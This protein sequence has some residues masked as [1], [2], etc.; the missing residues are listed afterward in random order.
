MA[1]RQTSLSTIHWNK[2]P[3]SKGGL[4]FHST[5]LF[6]AT[7]AGSTTTI[8]SSSLSASADSDFVGYIVECVK[9]TNSQNVGLLRRIKACDFASDTLTI[10]P[11][12]AATADEDQFHLYI[13]DHVLV[14]AQSA[15]S[16]TNGYVAARDRDEADDYWNG[17]TEEGGSYL[18]VVNADNASA[19]NHILIDDFT[20][21]TQRLQLATD[22]SGAVAIGDYFEL[23]KHPEVQGGSLLEIGMDQVERKPLSGRYGKQGSVNSVR[24]GSGTLEFAFRGPGRGREGLHCDL[25]DMF[26]C[27]MDHSDSGGASTVSGSPT[28]TNIPYSAGNHSV[29]DLCFSSEGYAGIITADSGSAYT[30]SPALGAAPVAGTSLFAGTTYTPSQ[31]INAAQCF[32]IWRGKDVLDYLWGCV[33][34]ISINAAKGEFLKISGEYSVSDWMRLGNSGTAIERAFYP[35]FPSTDQIVCGAGRIVIDGSSFNLRSATFAQGLEIAPRNNLNSPNFT[36][37]FEVVNDSPNGTIEVYYDSTERKAI[38]DF[39]N[40]KEVEMILQFGNAPGDSGVFV[41]WCNR[42]RYTGA[43]IGDD[44]GLVTLSLPFEVVNNLS[45]SLPRYAFGIF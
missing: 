29:G 12:P 9:A 36:D 31:G 4:A 35:K 27:V 2:Q 21:S 26:S 22:L 38:E 18:V 40:G 16:S 3:S 30:V 45:S 25:H 32:Q 39:L 11:L 34:N 15:A 5:R 13:P 7:D 19:T 17:S 14:I 24:N 37:G 28:T 41:L 10:D 23:W 33:P 1:P 42:I 44:A 8:V 6:A 20:N 43:T